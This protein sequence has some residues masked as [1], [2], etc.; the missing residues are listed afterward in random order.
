MDK[1]KITE[2][3]LSP[4]G[5][6]APTR[7]APD[8]PTAPISMGV[9]VAM[10]P[11]V[12]LLPVLCV[13]AFAMRPSLG[14][15]SPEIREAWLRFMGTLLAISGMI[16]VAGGAVLYSRKGTG[17]VG[18]DKVLAAGK[19]PVIL[20]IEGLS[21][22]TG[23]PLERAELKG[24]VEPLVFVADASSKPPVTKLT[25]LDDRKLG[26]ATILFVDGKSCLAIT[27]SDLL[28]EETPPALYNAQGHHAKP[29]LVATLNTF[30]LALVQFPLE[31]QPKLF[32]QPLGNPRGLAENS[33][34]FTMG[35]SGSELFKDK[36]GQ[37]KA[38]KDRDKVQ[39]D[40]SFASSW[41][42]GPVYDQSGNLL[43]IVTGA[44]GNDVVSARVVL[45]D[46]QWAFMEGK[47]RIYDLFASR[48]NKQ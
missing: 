46:T 20:K 19:A 43:G 38:M 37:L 33:V 1:L 35:H 24:K 45:N 41:K 14:H 23:K 40:L 5:V 47:K 4:P 17:P 8:A 32:V 11:L 29:E 26:A 39:T 28:K 42:G 13:M 27:S 10:A 31:R 15:K 12:L 3:D 44:R 34:V 2:A 36:E 25:D 18:D 6:D 48:L 7:N 22:F 21:N 9:R 30:N 16:Y